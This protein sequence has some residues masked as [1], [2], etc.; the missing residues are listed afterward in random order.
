MEKAEQSP[1][2]PEIPFDDYSPLIAPVGQPS[3]QAQQSMQTSGSTTYFVSPSEI[4]ETGQVAAQA[5]QLTHSS[6]ITCAILNPP[7]KF[8][9]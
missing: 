9:Y 1:V 8:Y 2:P 3:S 6:E 4:A 7:K 5:P